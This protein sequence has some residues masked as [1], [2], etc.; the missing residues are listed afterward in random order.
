M[1]SS[2]RAAIYVR[3]SINHPEGIERGLART[4]ALV[5]ERGWDLSEDHVYADNDTSAKKERGSQT[6][7][8]RLLRAVE[9][10]EVEVVVGVDLDR[11]IR[12][13]SDLVTL[14]KLDAKVVTVDGEIDLT[15]ADGRLRASIVTTMAAFEVER[16]SERQ[17][18]A[19]A[20][21]VSV[22][23][24]IPGRRRYGYEQGN[25]KVRAAEAENVRWLY[26]HIAAGGSVRSAALRLEQRTGWVRDVIQNRAYEGLIPYRVKDGSGYVRKWAESDEVERIVDPALA[27]KARAVLADPTRKT[28]TGPTPKHLASGIAVCGVC[29]ETIFYMRDY[30]CRKDASH[31]CIQ[32][33]RLD[34]LIAEEVFLWVVEHADAED[35]TASS[36]YL[37]LVKQL[38]E[39][40][41]QREAAESL[42]ILRK[43]DKSG[44]AR[45]ITE[46]DAKAQRLEVA[47][48]VERAR[49]SRIAIVET[50]RGEWWDKRADPAG[51]ET[52]AE[53]AWNGWTAYWAT[54]PVEQ[55]K[56]V[57]RS[58]FAIEVNPGRSDERVRFT[59]LEGA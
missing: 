7:W 54:I 47:I 16:K 51:S 9:A 1:T 26:E 27:E 30:R 56:E 21:R 31:P 5:K 48:Q 15:T 53:A 50:V 24:P 4:R 19:N 6:G 17:L 52:E 35:I 45:T 43:G 58:M 36:D 2:T 25:V 46:L 37:G 10:G 13:L 57:V 8:A 11:L 28:T 40:T 12:S 32:K 49:D 23:R 42:Y 14:I 59:W 39:V 34:R 41:E 55:Q 33:A 18:R 38:A 3:Q 29:Q 20:Y 22:G 44:L